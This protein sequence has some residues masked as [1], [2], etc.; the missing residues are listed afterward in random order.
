MFLPLEIKTILQVSEEK[1]NVEGT[2]ITPAIGGFFGVLIIV[3]SV[4][5]VIIY[6]RL[7]YFSIFS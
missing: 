6:R 4:V 1:E 3:V 7:V 5:V 2:P